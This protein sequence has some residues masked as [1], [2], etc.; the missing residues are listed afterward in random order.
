MA[1]TQYFTWKILWI[2]G[3]QLC[4][5]EI[6]IVKVLK[7]PLMMHLKLS[8]CALH[9]S[10]NLFIDNFERVIENCIKKIECDWLI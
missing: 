7:C 4:D 2:E 5:I 6:N 1:T 8:Q 9:I 3:W 10:Y